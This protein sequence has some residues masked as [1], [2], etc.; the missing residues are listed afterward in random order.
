MTT[1]PA[2][3][4]CFALAPFACAQQ[5]QVKV[6]SEMNAKIRAEAMDHSHVAEVFNTLTI[7]IGPRLTN[8]PAF[9][10]A[11]D[12]TKDRLT[13]YGLDN[14]HLEPWKFGRGWTLEKFTLEMT[15]PRYK[16]LIGYA[17]GWSAS[18]N[19][20][21]VAAPVYLGNKTKE[22]IQALL[23]TLK[24]Q[25]V[26]AYPIQTDFV[27]QDRPQPSLADTTPPEVLS[28][29]RAFSATPEARN[30]LTA[31]RKAGAGA[32]LRPNVLTD[33][34]VNVTGNDP[35]ADAIP[36]II[37]SSEQYNA[38]A[39]MIEHNIPLKLRVNLQGTYYTENPDAA[40]IIAEI[41]GTD[42][43][44]RDQVV[45][46]GAHVDS[47]HAAEGATD[48]AD[49]VT[50]MIEAMRILKAIGA[51]PRRTIRV[52]I[53]GGEEQGLLGSKAWVAQH[54]AESENVSVYFNSDNGTGKI[55]GFAMENNEGAKPYFDAWLAPFKDIGA[56][57]NVNLKLT[58]TDHLSF[59]AGGIPGFNPFQE[60]HDYDVRTHHTNMDTVE[61]VDLDDL[62]QSAIIMASFAWHAAMT[63]ERLPRK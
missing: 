60:Y 27:R 63:D 55:Y 4:I 16:P 6:D 43:A 49:G 26:M 37:V 38:I 25:I 20:E 5:P 48:N 12:F 45:M 34:T 30:L 50:T 10:K 47:W 7:D 61:H 42:P 62:K 52:A 18:T 29:S 11:V 32:M 1:R 21:L 9:R 40:N 23:P 57:R 28:P 44:L 17:E 46:L 22:Q 56:R 59:I 13:A 2:L 58:N 14:V 8:S 39:R 3:L 51:K 41:P 33:G 31:I 24:G 15:E 19:G 54:K 35:G 36:S 53:L